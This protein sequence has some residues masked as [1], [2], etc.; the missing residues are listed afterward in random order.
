M[1]LQSSYTPTI[2]PD[3]AAARARVPVVRVQRMPA[4]RSLHSLH[5]L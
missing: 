2:M 3:T 1:A 4:S 5:S